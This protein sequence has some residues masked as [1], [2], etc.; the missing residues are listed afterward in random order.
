MTRLSPLGRC[1]AFAGA[2]LV[3]LL[4][5]LADRFADHAGS[6]AGCDGLGTLDARAVP[7]PQEDRLE[8][9]RVAGCRRSEVQRR[10]AREV[11][12]GRLALLEAARWC[13]D[14]NETNP[15]FVWSDF[16][17]V[18]P[19]TSDDERHVRYVLAL[20]RAELPRGTRTAKCVTAHLE[21]EL[22]EQLRRGAV[23]LPR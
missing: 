22:A 11:I 12:A 20:V 23:G 8:A 18:Y 15:E 10:I 7:C 17:K 6:E 5:I 13:R 3:P 2:L 16:R 19:G 14:L 4:V 1:T 9:R 21:A